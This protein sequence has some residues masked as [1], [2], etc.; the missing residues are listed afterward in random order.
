MVGEGDECLDGVYP[1][2]VAAKECDELEMVDWRVWATDTTGL[3]ETGLD[4]AG[5]YSKG[6]GH[7]LGSSPVP[8]QVKGRVVVE[9]GHDGTQQD[10]PA[11]NNSVRCTSAML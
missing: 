1:S 5:H 3:D 6:L 4:D 9:D 2:R 7:A 10:I 8:V 11:Y